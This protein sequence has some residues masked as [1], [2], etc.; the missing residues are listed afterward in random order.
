MCA[1]L[2][3]SFLLRSRLSMLE[4][5][6]AWCVVVQGLRSNLFGLACPFCC[7]PCVGTVLPAF[8]ARLLCGFGLLAWFVFRFDLFPVA[9]AASSRSPSADPVSPAV[10]AS[11]GWLPACPAAT[12]KALR[13][14]LRSVACEPAFLVLLIALLNLWVT[15]PASVVGLPLLLRLCAL[16]WGPRNCGICPWFGLGLETRDQIAST[17]RVCPAWLL[18]WGNIAFLVPPCLA[19]TI[20]LLLGLL[21]AGLRPSWT[22]EFT[23]PTGIRHWIFGRGFTLLLVLTT[24]S[25]LWSSSH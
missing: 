19:V 13:S 23:P 10:V 20:L 14:S 22:P 3:R 1:S 11:R 18:S 6:S 17:F 16:V 4:V 8:L 9:P 21:V 2:I 7:T 12:T 24:F 5:P 15:C 25:V